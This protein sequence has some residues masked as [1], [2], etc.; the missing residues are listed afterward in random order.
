MHHMAASS[1]S[2]EPAVLGD[3]ALQSA[4]LEELTEA[5][6]YRGWLVSLALPYL[7][8]RPLEV[9]SGN[10]DYADEFASLGLKITASEAEPIRAKQLA[11]RFQTTPDV[12]VRELVLPA[13]EKGDYS[14]VVA[15][16]VLEHIPDDVAAVRGMAEL[17]R[18]GGAVVLLVP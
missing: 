2:A 6:N 7:G 15:Y 16:N 3:S 13:S 1:S 10:G 8:E 17:L 18:P 11:E 9:G 14:A 4:Q 12:T 5:V